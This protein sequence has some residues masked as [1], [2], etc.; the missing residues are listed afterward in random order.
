MSVLDTDDNKL[1]RADKVVNAIGQQ[2]NIVQRV[3]GIDEVGRGCWAGPLLVVAARA[4][5]AL[6]RTVADSKTLSKKKRQQLFDELRHCCEFGEGWVTH[7]EIDTIGLTDAMRLGTSR[8]LMNLQVQHDEAIII[9]GNI[10][11]CPKQYS[12]VQAII[13]ADGSVS[14]VSAAS[15]YAKVKRD[16]FMIDAANRYPGYGFESH[17]GYGTKLHVRALQKLG[18]CELHRLSYKPIQAINMA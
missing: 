16:T 2:V 11:Y 1:Y 4:I 5:I 9:D 8:A 15:V 7:N 18:V 14:A 13:G 6:P 3:V 10:N 12:H 17:V